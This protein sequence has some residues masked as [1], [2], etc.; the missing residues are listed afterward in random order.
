MLNKTDYITARELLLQ[1]AQPVSTERVP[2][3]DATGRV[4]AEDV[5]AAENVPSFDKSPY[6]GFAFRSSDTAGASESAPVTLRILEEVAA[7][8]V[9]TLACAEGTA[10]KILTGAPIPNGAD[11]VVM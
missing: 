2:L 10:V 5:R 6:D 11:A 8:A 9:P 4:L 1:T 7:G 3:W